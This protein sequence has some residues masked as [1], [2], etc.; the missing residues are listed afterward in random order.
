M[1]FKDDEPTWVPMAGGWFNLYTSLPG[2]ASGSDPEH[3]FKPGDQ[4]RETTSH[5]LAIVK[6]KNGI[7]HGQP[8]YWIEYD[9]TWLGTDMVK[10]SQLTL[11]VTPDYKQWSEPKC[12]C[13]GDITYGKDALHARYCDKFKE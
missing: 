1:T 5:E 9:N 3:K 7:S 6:T 8:A 12:V 10:E 11:I 2:G 4:V 13:G